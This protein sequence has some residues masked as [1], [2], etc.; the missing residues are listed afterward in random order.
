M[1]EAPAIAGAKTPTE[2]AALTH[3]R[4]LMQEFY[5]LQLGN[6]WQAFNPKVQSQWGT[7]AGFKAFRELGIKQYGKETKLVSERVFT[8]AG[9][10]YYARSAVFEKAPKL[11]WVLVIGFKQSQVTTFAIALD[12]NH[13]DD[14][15]A[16]KQLK[17]Y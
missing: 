14:Q 5:A 6:L 8:N 2:Q 17:L 16:Y 3:G 15:I 4:K 13:T 11:V 10:S 7:L 9:E 12:Q 1:A